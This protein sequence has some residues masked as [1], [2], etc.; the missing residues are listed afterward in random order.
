MNKLS[1]VIVTFNSAKYIY[2]CLQ[3]IYDQEVTFKFEVIVFDNNSSDDSVLFVNKYFKEVILLES[4]SNLGFAGANNE[5]VR[6]SNSDVLFLLNPDT[7]LADGALNLLN[8]EM[9]KHIN[10]SVIIAPMQLSMDT[11]DFLNYGL[12]LDIFGFP[13][14]EGVGSKFFYADGAAILIKK[15]DFINLGMFDEQLFLIQEDVD[16]AW[17]AR[18]MGFKLE[19][20]EDIVVFHKSGHSIGTGSSSPKVFST[21]A[22]RRYY[23]ERNS[24][25]NM[26]KN[27]SFYNLMIIIPIIVMISS[28]ETVMF[29]LLGKPQIAWAYVRA[30][31]WNLLNLRGTLQKRKWIQ[32]RRKV[33]DFTIMKNMYKGSAKLKLLLEVGIPKVK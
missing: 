31:H 30:Y 14:N 25:R 33:S 24:I 19:R 12:G 28:L 32:S 29:V 9:S 17:K 8:S 21:S 11:G 27:Y 6:H 5:A 16:L 3:S 10:N 23:G 13:L 2:Q 15:N 1:I 7:K 20:T 18:L 26:L 22:F 4:D